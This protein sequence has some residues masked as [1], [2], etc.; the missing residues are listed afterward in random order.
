MKHLL[1]LRYLLPLFFLSLVLLSCDD[2]EGAKPKV[3]VEATPILTRTASELQTFLNAAGI[4]VV[5][6]SLK[7]DV[8]IYRVTYKTE[9]KDDEVMASGLVILPKTSES[10]D[11]I[12]FQHGT[13][14]DYDEAPSALP[15]NSS[16]LILYSALASPGFVAVVPDF[17]GFG[18]SK[19][20]LH[21]YYV[22]EATTTAVLDALRAARE[23]ASKNGKNF[24]GELFLAGYSQGGYATMAAHQAIETAGLEGFELIASFPAAGGYDVKGMQE[25]FFDQETYDQPFYLAYVAMSYKSYYGWDGLLS[26]FFNEPYATRIPPLFNGTNSGGQINAQLTT[27]V[28]DLVKADLLA[29]IDNDP[30][31]NYLVDAFNENSLLDWTPTVPMFMYHGDAD[32]TVPYVNSVTS[33]EALINGGASPN[34]VKLISLPGADHSTGVIPYIEDFVPKVLSLK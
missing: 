4:D 30:K 10:I 9:Y 21:P 16:Q 26:D 24:N 32:V 1:K 27:T 13:I 6:G 14:V 7:Y 15:L 8:E 3:L 12:S 31:Y 11:M 29:Q 28:S 18:S 19:D 23:L 2:N 25:Y 20:I 5:A 22:K 33:Y 34:I 17:I